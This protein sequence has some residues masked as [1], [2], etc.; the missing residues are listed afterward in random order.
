LLNRAAKFIDQAIEELKPRWETPEQYEKRTGEKWPDNG[1]VYYQK[2][3][4]LCNTTVDGKIVN[5]H[6]TPF[7]WF[8]ET[9]SDAKEEISPEAEY[10]KFRDYG[11]V[12]CATEAGP[13]PD[14]REP[15]N[16]NMTGGKDDLSMD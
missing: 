2:R 1:A 14:T 8:V 12:I 15:E 3:T 10:R 5:E 6:W 16:Q 11:L 9:W 13:P 7:S 4:V